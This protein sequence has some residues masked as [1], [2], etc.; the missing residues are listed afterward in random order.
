[1]AF[2]DPRRGRPDGA[3]RP[4]LHEPC[5]D[6]E[7]AR[8]LRAD[9]PDGRRRCSWVCRV[10]LFVLVWRPGWRV[11][12]GSTIP[13]AGALRRPLP[14]NCPR[15][16]LFCPR[17][18]RRD[19]HRANGG[20][21]FYP[22]A[23]ILYTGGHRPGR[24]A[25]LGPC[26]VLR[27]R[28]GARSSGRSHLEFVLPDSADCVQIRPG[29]AVPDRRFPGSS[30]GLML[31]GMASHP[32]EPAHGSSSS[33]RSRPRHRAGQ[34]DRVEL[35]ERLPGCPVSPR[36]GRESPSR[37][38]RP[39]PRRS[40]RATV[41]FIARPRPNRPRIGALSG[42]VAVPCRS[43]PGSLVH[44]L[45]GGWPVRPDDVARTSAVVAVLA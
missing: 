16:V 39:R 25:L 17:R 36:R 42:L 14:I 2:D 35:R 19:P 37:P 1:M 9:R 44:V 28:R 34:R 7:T 5:A 11:L 3:V 23:P 15:P 43:C 26:G 33:I 32:I 24:L 6:D 31:P 13:P 4:D 12:R 8:S 41:D 27:R 45:L 21:G 38:F 40:P 22:V 20:S 18:P 10:V 29:F 30:S